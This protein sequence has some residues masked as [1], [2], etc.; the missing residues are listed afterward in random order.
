MIGNRLYLLRKAAG[1]SQ[2]ELG[3]M[4][5][6]SHHTISAYE[7]EKS[8]PSDA[9]KVWLA[10]FFG[11]SVDY[12]MGSV[13]SATQAMPPPLPMYCSCPRG[14]RRNSAAR[15]R[16][17]LFF[18][19]SAT[20]KLASVGTRGTVIS[21]DG[22]SGAS[23]FI[24][25]AALRRYNGSRT[26][27]RPTAP[28]ANP[29]SKST[30]KEVPPY[31]SPPHPPACPCCIVPAAPAPPPPGS[32]RPE[33]DGPLCGA[34]ATPTAVCTAPR[35]ASRKIAFPPSAALWKP[36]T[37]SNS[38]STSPPMAG[39]SSSTMTPWTASAASPAGWMKNPMPNCSSS[40]CWAPKNASPSS[41][42]SLTSSR[43]RSP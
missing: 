16:I 40:A 20:D 12:L 38:T 14:L 32:L 11:V 30:R 27:G 28:P 31:E 2:A 18:L 8:D 13:M 35:M 33:E 10:R 25:P 9:T 37:A 29:P 4:L 6:V 21:F 34:A 24:A 42:R 5:S 41:Q 3:D 22:D 19:P 15:S 39:L 36:A 17:M 23:F 7:K 26:G 43:G 1:L